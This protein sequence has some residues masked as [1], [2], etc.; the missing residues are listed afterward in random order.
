MFGTLKIMPGRA[1]I[2][3]ARRACGLALLTA[4]AVVTPAAASIHPGDRV[5]V[6]VYNH[7]ELS[8]QTTVDGSGKISLPLAGGVDTTN[9][10]PAQIAARVR[11][12][13]KP[14]V[15]KSPSTFN[16]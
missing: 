13:L 7:P 10:D 1:R 5:A 6:L 14:Y 2:S 12:A 15:P 4:A 9:L 11:Y 8:E 16:S 3:A